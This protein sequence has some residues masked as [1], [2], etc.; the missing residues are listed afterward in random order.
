MLYTK[1]KNLFRTFKTFKFNSA[2][3]FYLLKYI[4]GQ[5]NKLNYFYLRNGLNVSVNKNAGDLTTLFEIFING[6]YSFE[7]DR[8]QKFNILDIGA[9]V[10]YYSLYANKIFPYAKIYS[11]EPFP[12]TFQ[13]LAD[14]INRNN[15]KNITAFP[16]AVS[17]FNGESKFYTFDWAG[18]NTLIDRKFDEGHHKTT[19]VNCISFNDLF[20]MTGVN[21]FMFGKIDCEGSEYRIFLNSKDEFI[22]LIKN[23]II[24]VH[25]DNKFSKND[26]I[27][28]FESLGYRV[29]DKGGLIEACRT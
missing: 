10:G 15:G 28:R 11:F 7:G 12:G 21:E 6:D 4:K 16:F 9:N 24:E 26:L 17:D 1:A 2:V 23:Y 8:N 5:N 27:K 25:D 3:K 18:C 20:K 22:R 13:R 19:T 14:N 29:L